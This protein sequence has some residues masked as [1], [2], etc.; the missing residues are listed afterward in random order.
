MKKKKWLQKEIHPAAIMTFA[1]FTAALLLAANLWQWKPGGYIPYEG[2]ESRRYD[3]LVHMGFTAVVA[4]VG[5]Y[6]LP[7][8]LRR[9]S[10][11]ILF[12]FCAVILIISVFFDR[13]YTLPRY[14]Y[15][16]GLSL[17]IPMWYQ[18]CVFPNAAFCGAFIKKDKKKT[19][20]AWAVFLAAV[21]ALGLPVKTVSALA[22]LILCVLTLV[23]FLLKETDAHV[24]LW[25]PPLFAALLIGAA[26]VMNGGPVYLAEK[27]ELIFNRGTNDPVGFGFLRVQADRLI[28]ALRLF[29]S[30]ALTIEANG[31]EAPL[32]SFLVYSSNTYLPLGIMSQ[33]GYAGGLVYYLLQCAAAL[34]LW[35]ASKKAAVP[36][37]KYLCLAVGA[38]FIGQVLLNLLSVFWMSFYCTPPFV[39]QGFNLIPT[40]VV[41]FGALGAAF[42]KQTEKERAASLFGGFG[43]DAR[44]DDD[45][46]FAPEDEADE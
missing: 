13:S 4:G 12:G 40:V 32:D 29:G 2:Y 26:L 11:L 20:A 8:R 30:E 25:L 23:C 6:L 46:T 3:Q 39:G 9:A 36:E 7:V 17:S 45:A 24:P 27:L 16:F 42:S 19:A 1:V 35:F 28:E 22:A 37:A 41:Y 18:F 44:Q 33:F 21:L 34:C 15:V 5:A 14:N 31:V 10:G 43:A 38:L